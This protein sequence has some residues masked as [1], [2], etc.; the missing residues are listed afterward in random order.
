MFVAKLR[1]I[2]KSSKDFEKNNTGDVIFINNYNL[3]II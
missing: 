1:I 2:Q 3:R